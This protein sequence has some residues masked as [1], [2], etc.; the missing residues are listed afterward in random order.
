[1]HANHKTWK[2]QDPLKFNNLRNGKD[3]FLIRLMLPAE[4]QDLMRN[5]YEQCHN[6]SAKCKNALDITI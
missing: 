1:M 5:T 2:L 3:E 6:S 4:H